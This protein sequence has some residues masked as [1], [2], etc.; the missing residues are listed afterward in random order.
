MTRSRPIET[1]A[2]ELYRAFWVQSHD[3]AVTIDQCHTEAIACPLSS[4]CREQRSE[5]YSSSPL[6]KCFMVE[7][8]QS[9]IELCVKEFCQHILRSKSLINNPH[10][11]FWRKY[12]R[13]LHLKFGTY[14]CPDSIRNP[15]AQ[16]AGNWLYI[17][18]PIRKVL[19]AKD[20]VT[21]DA[22]ACLRNDPK[23]VKLN[24]QESVW[25]SPGRTCA[26]RKKSHRRAQ[27]FLAVSDGNRQENSNSHIIFWAIRETGF[28]K[29]GSRTQPYLSI[30]GRAFEILNNRR[31]LPAR[32]PSLRWRTV[33][34]RR[35]N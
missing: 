32:A 13:A 9:D 11:A 22:I 33:C 24:K 18:R 30:K 8:S 29:D 23:A 27:V 17:H 34:R 26:S 6:C 16:C 35:M 19:T 31:R 10:G 21:K 15:S 3:I 28:R 4:S 1:I 20:L 7:R 25:N 5:G 14:R 12:G 2:C